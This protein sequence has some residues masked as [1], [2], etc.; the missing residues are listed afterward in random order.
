MNVIASCYVHTLKA[1]SQGRQRQK[2]TEMYKC[3]I[4]IAFTLG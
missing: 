1:D 4:K 2:D 3:M